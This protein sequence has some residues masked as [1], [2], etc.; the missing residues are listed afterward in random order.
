MEGVSLYTVSKILRH[1]TV[2]MTERYAHLR[3]DKLKEAVDIL[4]DKSRFGHG[5]DIKGVR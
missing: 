4:S 2:K 1:S 5:R 3:D